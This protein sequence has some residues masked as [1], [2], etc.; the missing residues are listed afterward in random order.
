MVVFA[1]VVELKKSHEIKLIVVKTIAKR[2]NVFSLK[3]F[4][5]IIFMYKNYLIISF[6]C[7][8]NLVRKLYSIL[9]KCDTI[10]IKYIDIG[11]KDEKDEKER[12]FN[13]HR[14]C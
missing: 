14:W 2:I 1:S 7:Q 5:Y 8:Y 9:N 3:T 11:E 10:C 6:R 13:G 12:Y 4:L